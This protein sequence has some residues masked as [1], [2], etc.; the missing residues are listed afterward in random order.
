MKVR[1]Q[2]SEQAHGHYASEDHNIFLVWGCGHVHDEPERCSAISLCL[3]PG[4]HLFDGHRFAHEF[5]SI[6]GRDSCFGLL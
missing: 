3:Q 6:K 1:F 5:C 2:W 4:T